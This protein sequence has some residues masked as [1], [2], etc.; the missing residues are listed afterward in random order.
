MNA[1]L[2]KKRLLT[3]IAG[4]FFSY[5]SICQSNAGKITG[6]VVNADGLPAENLN[7]ELKKAHR[8]TNTDG[9]GRFVLSHLGAL[10]DTLVISSVDLHSFIIPIDLTNA[11][12]LDLGDI[13]L[14]YNIK[15]LQ[16][17][18]IKGRALRSYKSDYSFLATKTEA[19]V[20]DIPQSISTITKELIRDKMEFTK[21]DA[22]DAA[23]GVTHYSGYDEYTIRGFRAENA[24]NING[25][26]G[27]NST[28]TSSMLVNIE[29][30]EVIKGPVASL[31]GN[32]DPGGTINM[33]TKK[34]LDQQAYSIDLYGGSYNH[35]RAQGDMT[36]PLNTGKTLLYRFNAGYDNSR[37]FRDQSFNKAYQLAPSFSFIPNTRL[38]INVDFS[39]SHVSTVLDR[40]Q[41]GLQDDPNL[42]STPLNLTL[43]Q[44]GDY[45]KE[46]DLALIATASYKLG[47]NLSF[48]AGYLHYNTRQHVANHGFDDYITDDS[49]Y[50]N[51]TKWKYNTTTNTLSDYFT[52]QTRT[53]RLDHKILL[54]YDFI[55]SRVDIDQSFYEQPD[56]FGD[57]SGIVGTF[58]LKGPIYLPRPV[59]QYEPSDKDNDETEVDGDVYYTHG[60]YVQDFISF[61]RWKFL[62]GLRQEFYRG[63]GDDGD[64][65]IRQNIL[66]W[67]AGVVYSLTPTIS[68]YGSYNTGFD[69]FEASG[70]LQTF[71]EP[72]KPIRSSLA[73]IGAKTNLPG[74]KLS[75]S[76]AVYRLL[77]QNVAVNANDISNPDLFVQQGQNR[78]IGGEF[79]LNGNILPNL[80]VS[81]AYAYCKA[82]ITKSKISDD[83]GRTVENAP[84]NLSTSWI[85][86]SLNKGALKGLGISLGHVYAGQRNTL[87]EQTVLPAYFILNSSIHYQWKKFTVGVLVNNLTD[88][89]YWIAAYNNVAKWP[90]APRN[91]MANV[92]YRF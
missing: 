21:K 91:M 76:I 16:N 61:H 80:S 7:I 6:R 62:A 51:F 90:G 12:T 56:Q 81:L 2:C 32:G 39:L 57:N 28:Y 60:V 89:Q 44:P 22:L 9:N 46:T 27:Y 40:G 77:V 30:I 69:P 55:R 45:L 53:G 34:P 19:P 68:L 58:S 84:R 64:E 92:G 23:A 18:E 33:V 66:T 3:A 49:V 24:G 67:R 4:L 70:T 43:S 75:A 10:H 17:V 59:D 50:L 20:K 15:E 54:G 31:Y 25:L 72:L 26:R 82:T 47:K 41:P 48:N 8:I 13:R 36:G 35:F 86:Y 11:Q 37:S 87:D 52:Y 88:R 74:N 29:R 65:G 38:K 14:T 1:F 85:N 71:N 83:I 42:K 73:E 78:S 63:S 79:E 5:S